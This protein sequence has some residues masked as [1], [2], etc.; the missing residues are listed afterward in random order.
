MTDATTPGGSDDR[1][2]WPRWVILALQWLAIASA[3]VGG[4]TAVL[5]ALGKLGDTSRATCTALGMCH[6]SAPPTSPKVVTPT[7]P[8]PPPA[9]PR[10]A[11]PLIANADSGWIGGGSSPQKFCDGVL[12]SVKQ[13]YPGF[14]ISMTL[15]P[16]EHRTEHHPFKEDYYR[17]QCSFAAIYP[18]AR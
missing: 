3:L 13:K 11:S 1:K 15:L 17:Y 18:A 7:R 6:D 12:P 4:L 16:E 10:P 5:A 14:Q 2:P 8:P 9:L